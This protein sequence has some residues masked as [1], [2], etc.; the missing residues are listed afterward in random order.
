MREGI[1]TAKPAT[2]AAEIEG[3][4]QKLDR[5]IDD[6]LAD[7]LMT[8]EMA[9]IDGDFGPQANQELRAAMRILEDIEV[10]LQRQVKRLA[11]AAA[12][13]AKAEGA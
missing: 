4:R 10:D 5:F 12:W 7:S 13:T 1:K 9:R 8:V 3:V 2:L 11:T 6:E